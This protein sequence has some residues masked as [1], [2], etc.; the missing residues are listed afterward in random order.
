MGSKYINPPD[1]DLKHIY[2]DSNPT[3]PFIFVLSPGAAPFEVLKAFAET[4]RK[5]IKFKSLGQGQG[6]A[7]EALI[8]QC[9]VSGDW[10]F[11]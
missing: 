7:A 6:D 9:I 1:F 4:K 11:L 10:V 5:E 3:T 2:N 8:N